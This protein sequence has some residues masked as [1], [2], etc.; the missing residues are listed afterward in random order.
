MTLGWGQLNSTIDWG[1]LLDLRLVICLDLQHGLTRLDLP[2]RPTRLDLTRPS[3]K[4][5]SARPLAMVDLT[6]PL[7]E[8]NLS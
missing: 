1:N 3:T 2:P 6:R 5:D 7:V 8:D 4:V